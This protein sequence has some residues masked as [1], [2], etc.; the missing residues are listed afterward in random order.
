M[1][2]PSIGDAQPS[3]LR[4]WLREPL[5]HFLLGGFVLFAAYGALNPQTGDRFQSNRIQLTQDELRMMV[6][7]WEAK[8]QRPPTPEEMHSLVEDRV[9]EEILYREAQALGLDQGDT[10]VKRRLAQKIEFLAEDTSA[11]REPAPGELKAWFERN[12]ERFAQSG[13]MSFSHVYF[14]PDRHGGGVQDAASKALQKLAGQPADSAAA[15]NAGDRFMFQDYY[16]DREPEQLASVFG[17]KFAQ[18]LFQLTPGAWQGPLES[19]LGWHLV[20]IESVAPGRVPDFEEIEPDLKTA[21]INEQRA[22]AKR[23]T[24][25]AMR[26][27]YE[28]VLPTTV[29]REA[30]AAAL[31]GKSP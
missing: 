16:A 24:Y 25:A 22:K 28:V 11:I 7:A 29:P 4:R 20:F 26:A 23:K 31:A 10:I 27:R 19:G 9:H 6:V 1:K 5:L 8:W 30:P 2:G 13:R 15:A 17:A 21:W 12:R 14:S 3:F 18:T